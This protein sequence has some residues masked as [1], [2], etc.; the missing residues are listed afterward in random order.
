MGDLLQPACRDAGGASLV[1]LHLLGVRPSAAP[2]F[3]WLIATILRRMR[4]RAP[5]CS[6]VGFG[7]IFLPMVWR[8]AMADRS[9]KL[10]SR[11]RPDAGT[12]DITIQRVIF[13]QRS[14]GTSRNVRQELHRTH[15]PGSERRSY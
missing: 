13:G 15:V 2:S 3:S 8:G 4:T 5:T 1:F 7:A 10:L 14:G 6:S 9:L 12:V 11:N